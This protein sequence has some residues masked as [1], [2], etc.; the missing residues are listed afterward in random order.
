MQNFVQFHAIDSETE[1]PQEFWENE[2]AAPPTE[3]HV[4][5]LHHCY[6]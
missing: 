4:P 3:L 6:L 5:K 1:L 2:I